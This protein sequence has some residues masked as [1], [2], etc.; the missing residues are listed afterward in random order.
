MTTQLRNFVFT[1]N[2]P[3][4]EEEKLLTTLSYKY[5]IYG[6]EKGQS[7]TPH[8]QGYCELDK[9]I[10][11]NKMKKFISR[12]HIEPRKGTAKQAA[13]YCKKDGDFV[14]LGTISN[15]GKRTDLERFVD[16]VKEER[17]TK[18]QL[19]EQHTTTFARYPRFVEAVIATYHPPEVMENLDFHWYHGATGTGKS[20]TAREENPGAYIK[21]LNKWW[22][23]YDNEPCV[24][25][26]EWHPDLELS[27]GAHLKRWA[28]HYPFQAEVKGGTMFI[29][30]PRIIV[31]SN[32]KLFD[33]FQKSENYEPLERRFKSREFK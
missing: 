2:N 6:R 14:E 15:P 19:I 22:D 28:D 21:N 33:C 27:L 7:G 30:P 1:L 32:F 4:D 11:F 29:R 17:P 5:L 8:L 31:T 13:D 18:K 16:A 3:T 12:M 23:N 26:D 24:I 25:I 9:K 10:S 20:R